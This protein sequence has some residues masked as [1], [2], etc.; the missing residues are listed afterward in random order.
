[1]EKIKWLEWSKEAFEKAKRENKP[2]LLDIHGVWC[3]WCHVQEE[4]YEDPIVIETIN[5]KFIP[6]KVDTDK[7]PDINE[8]YNQGGWPTTAFLTPDGMLIAGATYLPA[9]QLAIM[10]EQVSNYYKKNKDNLQ[11]DIEKP[12]RK[13]QSVSHSGGG[14][15]KS[16]IEEVMEEMM[17]SFDTGYGGFG[18]EPKFPLPDTVELALLRFKQS[19]DKSALKVATKTLDGMMGI[20]DEV[21]GGFFRYSVTREWNLPHYEK[22]LETNAQ[23]ILNYIHA[24]RITGE[25]KYR[26][27]AER[28]AQFL[29]RILHGTDG[30][31]GS[32]DADKEEEYYGKPLEERKKMPQP[33][34]DK[35]VYTNLNALAISAFLELGGRYAGIALETIENLWRKC[36]S[37]NGMCHYFDGKPNVYGLLSD[38]I[39]FARCLMDAYEK[40][41]DKNYIE[42]VKQLMDFAVEKF[43]D[44][45]FKDR[46]GEDVGLLKAENRS[47]S[48]NSI[49]AECLVRLAFYTNETRYREFA[50][51]TLAGF[52]KVYGRF[53]LHAAGYAIAVERFLDPIEITLKNPADGIPFDPRI[54]VKFD[55]SQIPNVIICSAG[56]CMKFNDLEEAR[57]AL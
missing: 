25:E 10:L 26:T 14:E 6:I 35:N 54:M 28:T 30:F 32:Q 45:G 21:E 47:V 8:R 24:F 33:F 56:K 1:M 19:G 36:F 41:G 15:I 4:S 34:I 48:E 55:P 42:K 49:A 12:N 13:T 50:E 29:I 22:M 23:L 9:A 2:V 27:V 17:L 57:R 11:F 37:E 16:V 43:F 44:A 51:K 18:S 7:R 3:H 31:Y 52:A 46:I 5:E 20:F 40:T 53:R 39:N 38:N